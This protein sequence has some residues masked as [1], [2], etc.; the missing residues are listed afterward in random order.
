MGL[1]VKLFKNTSYLTIGNQV[2]NILQF[3][4]FL[5]FARK[6][7]DE[8]VGQYSFAFSFTYLFSVLA[9]MG[10]S[11]YMIREVAREEP[12]KRQ[13]FARCMSV[14]LISLAISSM[15]AIFVIA[16]FFNKFSTS[17]IEIII[18]LGIY[19]IFFSIADIFLS[20]F[21]GHDRMGMVALLNLAGRF[22]ISCAGIFLVF[23]GFDFITVLTCFPAGA[24]AYFI[25]CLLM[26][27]RHF[28]DVKPR[29][30]D[31]ELRGLIAAIIPFALALIFIETFHNQDVLMLK[32]LQND[33]A[34]GIYSAANKIILAFLG[35][36]FFIHT[37]LLPTFSRLYI[38]SRPELINIARKT[39]RYLI[40][41]SLP[42]ATGLYAVSGKLIVFLYSDAFQESASSI[43][44]LSW[45]IA[46]GFVAATYSVLL[47]AINRQKEKVIVIGICLVFNIAL[48][49]LLI[50]RLSY[51]GAASAKLMTE[52]LFFILMAHLVSKY[53]TSISAYRLLVKPALSCLLMYLFIQM[54]Y[55]LNLIFLILIS[56]FVYFL[57]LAVMRGYTKEEIDFMKQLYSKRIFN[58][59]FFKTLC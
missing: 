46:F 41:I 55:Q 47:T 14:R 27:L 2:G 20:E 52:A 48:N 10:L 26:S 21:K 42:I 33:R 9:D 39:L 45:T 40:V 12:G 3:L 18:L 8:I 1:I 28:K 4:F 37:A 32:F 31:L 7:G 22:L 19:Q 25:L 43:A 6:F 44:I 16:V 56:S 51:N 50:P 58:N 13:I 15:L 30:K 59:Q 5:F 23:Q 53:L 34:V 54:F 17:Y 36:I 38:E 35:I 11:A 49:L 57:S 29:F 24:F